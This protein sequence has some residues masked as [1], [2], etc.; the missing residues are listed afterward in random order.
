MLPDSI[1]TALPLHHDGFVITDITVKT[2]SSLNPLSACR[3]KSDSWHPI[4]KDLYLGTGWVSAAYLHVQRKKEEELQA[5]DKV[6]VDVRVGRLDPGSGE[7][8]HQDERWSHRPAGLWILKSSKSHVSDSNRALTGVDVLY[9]A[10]AAEPRLGWTIAQTPLLL[11]TAEY[12]VRVSFRRGRSKQA[13]EVAAPR[14]RADGK[15]K[16]LQVSDLHLSTG[17]GVCRDTI[18]AKGDQVKG[19]CEADVRALDFVESMIIDEKPDMIVLSGDQLEGPAVPDAQSVSTLILI[20][21]Y[22]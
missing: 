20:M 12:L 2:C 22:G 13:T 19:Q 4:E 21:I 18:D 9:G 6:V 10:D 3:I 11:D 5:T 14:I 16:I 8:G 17:T 7:S 15:F 1:H